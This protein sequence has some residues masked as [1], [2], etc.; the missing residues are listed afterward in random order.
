MLNPESFRDETT[1]RTY[2]LPR[3]KPPSS[4]ALRALTDTPPYD[5][6]IGLTSAVRL[7][8]A[9]NDCPGDFGLVTYW[10]GY[11]WLFLH[12]RGFVQKDGLWKFADRAR[13]QR[14]NDRPMTGHRPHGQQGDWDRAQPLGNYGLAGEGEPMDEG[15]PVWV[16]C[17]HGPHLHRVTVQNVRDYIARAT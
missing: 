6:R 4:A 12:Q 16:Q 7:R 3:M 1:G 13:K 17:D 2:L 8:C 10:G 11:Y 9:W 5:L 15:V 14:N